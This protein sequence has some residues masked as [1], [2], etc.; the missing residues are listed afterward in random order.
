MIPVSHRAL[1]FEPEP[2]EA[3][4]DRYPRAAE[5]T[6]DTEAEMAPDAIRPGEVRAN[7]FDAESGL[8]LVVC[9]ERYRGRAY[10]HVWADAAPDTPLGRLGLKPRDFAEHALA[11]WRELAGDEAPIPLWGFLAG[12]PH[13][14]RLLTS[15]GG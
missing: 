3:L 7:V 4:R 10:L 14:F 1:P 2:Y 12:R 9:R 15:A 6:Y 11:C 8:R 5:F 13:W